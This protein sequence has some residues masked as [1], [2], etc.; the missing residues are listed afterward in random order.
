MKKLAS[1]F[2]RHLFIIPFFRKHYYGIIARLNKTG[3]FKGVS[4]QIVFDDD[5][6]L[7]ASIEDWVPQQVYFLGE[8][9]SEHKETLYWKNL[10]KQGDV[11]I[12]AGANFGYYTLMAAKRCGAEGKVYSFEPVYDTFQNLTE[13]IVLNGFQ[14]IVANNIALWDKKEKLKIFTGKKNNT[15]MSAIAEHDQFS[16]KIEY[17]E[18]ISLD[19]FFTENEIQKVNVIKIDVEGSEP[20]ILQGMKTILQKNSPVVLV[21]VNEVTLTAAGF[22]PLEIFSLLENFG[23]TSYNI[24]DAGELSSSGIES[25]DGLTVFIRE[26]DKS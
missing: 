24:N 18:A 15:G 11:I 25:N 20:Y 26:S 5:I 7:S 2:L 19:E 9:D 14:N 17:V 22:K 21:E 12:D 3:I 6:I 16:G 4:S 10:V 13:N 8:Y 1:T 23:Y